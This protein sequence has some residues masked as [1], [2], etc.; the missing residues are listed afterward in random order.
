MRFTLAVG[1]PFAWLFF[2]FIGFYEIFEKSGLFCRFSLRN[3]RPVLLMR[4]FSLD[5]SG[6]DKSAFCNTKAF[7]HRFSTIMCISFYNINR[8]QNFFYFTIVQIAF[9]TCSCIFLFVLHKISEHVTYSGG[10]SLLQGGTRS[11]LGPNLNGLLPAFDV[12]TMTLP[13]KYEGVILSPGVDQSPHSFYP[14]F[15][16]PS[17]YTNA[18]FKSP[19]SSPIHGPHPAGSAS[20]PACIITPPLRLFPAAPDDAIFWSWLHITEAL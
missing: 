17:E 13:D 2:Y 1:Y 6:R 8:F 16:I 15:I 7:C 10:G 11:C 19:P 9:M 20:S 12:L 5:G 4:L 14:P 3:C 18:R